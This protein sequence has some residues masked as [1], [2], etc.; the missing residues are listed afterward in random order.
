MPSVSKLSRAVQRFNDAFDYA[1]ALPIERP[2]L[3]S[4]MEIARLRGRPELAD[5]IAAA[6]LMEGAQ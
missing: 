5:E 2:H 3:N 4:M 6:L 1:M